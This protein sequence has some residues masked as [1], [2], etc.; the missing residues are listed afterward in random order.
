MSEGLVNNLMES[1]SNMAITTFGLNIGLNNKRL[2]AVSTD[3]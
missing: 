1:I 2:K 3:D